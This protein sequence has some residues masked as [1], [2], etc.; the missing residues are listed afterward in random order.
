V[1]KI[2]REKYPKPPWVAK[3]QNNSN[4]ETTIN[5]YGTIIM[6]EQPKRK[7]WKRS[8]RLGGLY[9]SFS[10]I[11]M[12]KC[13]DQRVFQDK[14]KMKDIKRAIYNEHEGCCPICGQ[15]YEFDQM[16]AHHILPWS[17]FPEYRESI[18]NID[19]YCV[20]CH[21][22]LHN[23]PWRMIE[24]IKAKAQELGINLEERYGKIN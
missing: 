13:C 7:T 22:E 6:A 2:P 5:N 19:V 11:K 14:H 8:F 17:K 1:H 16:E 21:K 23:N 3:K 15:H 18:E 9:I 10:N 4:M 24:Q 20:K 12:R